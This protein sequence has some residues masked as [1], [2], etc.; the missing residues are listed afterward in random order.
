MIRSASH[1]RVAARLELAGSLSVAKTAATLPLLLSAAARALLPSRAACARVSGVRASLGALRMASGGRSREEL[2]A[3]S[4]DELVELVLQKEG[5]RA[6]A[7]AAGAPQ[8]KQKAAPRAFDMSKH[9]QHHVALRIAY[10]GHAYRGLMWLDDYDDTVEAR[11]FEALLKT[12]LIEDRETCEFS[13]GGRTDKGVSALGQVVALRIRSN[14]PLAPADGDAADAPAA[15]F[16]EIDYAHKLNCVLPADIRVLAW[17]PVGPSFSARFSATHRT[18]KY[19]F[20]RGALDVAKMREA[21]ALLVGQHDYRN[22]CKID[23]S[24]QSFERRILSFEVAPVP[25]LAVNGGDDSPLA[26][27]EFTVSGTAFLWHQVRA[28]AAILFLVG[29]RHEEPSIVARLLDVEAQPRRPVYDIASEAPLLLYNIGYDLGGGADIPWVY[30]AATLAGVSQLWADTQAAS[31]LKATSLH[32]MRA[33]LLGCAVANPL[34]GEAARPTNASDARRYDA[35]ATAA[36]ARTTAA[37][38]GAPLDAAP[39]DAAD[40]LIPWLRAHALAPDADAAATAA[41]ARGGRKHKPLLERPT[42]EPPKF[43]PREE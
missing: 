24:V 6:P 36:A 41:R 40:A 18:Y 42:A 16:E 26:L 5:K 4:K 10:L 35:A 9:S 21:A 15:P 33:S 8:K 11:L 14:R 37:A 19:C 7:A 39:P 2:S 20:V 43:A 38:V 25:G 31:L 23:P 27:W 29:Q 12:C 34:H 3:L 32:T 17:H 28:M 30:S 1:D 13:R 22:F